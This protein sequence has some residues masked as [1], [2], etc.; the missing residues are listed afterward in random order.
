MASSTRI[1]PKAKY[2]GGLESIAKPRV[3]KAAKKPASVKIPTKPLASKPTFAASLKTAI[4]KA[5]IDALHKVVGEIEQ[6]LKKSLGWRG[7]TTITKNEDI[8]RK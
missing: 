6:S 7:N 1:N 5:K 2:N 3:E 4:Q 8:S